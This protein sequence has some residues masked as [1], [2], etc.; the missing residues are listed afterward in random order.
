MN[1]EYQHFKNAL[2][3]IECA[4]EQKTRGKQRKDTEIT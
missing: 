3:G 4:R 2:N 1:E